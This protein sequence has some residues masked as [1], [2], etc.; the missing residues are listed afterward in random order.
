MTMNSFE[1]IREFNGRRRRAGRRGFG[2][3]D[4]YPAGTA[5]LIE[6]ADSLG[7]SDALLGA[8]MG[9]SPVTAR[10]L[11]SETRK[12]VRVRKGDP[13]WE[14]PE[15]RFGNFEEL[16]W[17]ITAEIDAGTKSLR[18]TGNAPELLIL[19]H[20]KGRKW[21]DIAR[22]L[23]VSRDKVYDIAMRHIWRQK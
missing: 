15:R 23:G 13:H 17:H 8:K 6:A 10:G 11:R 20:E 1:Q 19:E 22:D 21:R 12:R 4:L 3:L 14:P 16:R 7:W 9:V 5:A 2:V 18:W